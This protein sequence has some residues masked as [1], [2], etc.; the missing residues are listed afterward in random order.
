LN[1]TPFLWLDYRHNPS[2]PG[3]YPALRA[4]WTASKAVHPADTLTTIR[5][6]RPQFLCFEFDTPSDG[7]LALLHKTHLQHPG[8][9][10]LMIT[11]AA[12]ASGTQATFRLGVWDYLVN[13]VTAQDLNASI[14]AF[15]RFCR[16]R[17]HGGTGSGSS[18]E[19]EQWPKTGMARQYLEGHFADDVRQ[20]FLAGLCHLSVSEFSRCFRKEHGLP[21]S[22]FLLQLRVRR[23]SELLADP[24]LPIKEVAFDVGF[25][26]VSYFARAFHRITGLTPS[27]YRQ[28]AAQGLPLISEP[29]ECAA[30]TPL[31]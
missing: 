12:P 25:N 7:D 21:F 14:D 13:P 16:Q 20:A 6:T 24:I 26:D 5:D 23:A 15:S 29:A 19:L 2:A 18:K 30:A 22:A 4:D 3:L 28:R 17:H 31:N 1:P 9:P 10:I 27:A 11:E 8:L